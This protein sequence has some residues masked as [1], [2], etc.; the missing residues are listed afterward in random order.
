MPVSTRQQLLD[1]AVRLFAE[2][3]FHGASLARIADELGLTKQALLHH[4]GTKE[5]L[6]GEILSQVSSTMLGRVRQ[7]RLAEARPAEQLE[8]FFV[9]YLAVLPE[10]VDRVQLLMR[11]LLDNRADAEK[12]KTWYLRGFLDEL[13]EIVRALPASEPIDEARAFAFVYSLLG[14]VQYFSVSQPTLERMYGKRRHAAFR[15]AMSTEVQAL[16]RA[17]VST[18]GA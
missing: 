18:L 16:L 12:P 17:R 7:A 9:D 8:V 15:R 5:R 4:F 3:G 1:A 14:A 10:D 11:E 6:Y 13:V 2:R